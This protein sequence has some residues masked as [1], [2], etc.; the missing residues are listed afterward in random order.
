M[1]EC[2][3]GCST[4]TLKLINL[5]TRKSWIR[6]G[7]SLKMSGTFSTT[8]VTIIIIIIWGIKL[9]IW[10]T[11]IG[12]IAVSALPEL[13]WDHLDHLVRVWTLLN[14]LHLH[15]TCIKMW[16]SFCFFCRLT[17]TAPRVH[18]LEGNTCEITWETIPP[19]RGDP[20]SYVL[21]VLVG[22][23]SEY[24]QVRLTRTL[25]HTHFIMR[26]VIRSLFLS[27]KFNDLLLVLF[28]LIIKIVI[29]TGHV[30]R[31]DS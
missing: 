19:M 16:R 28:H 21:Q 15:A 20:V 13:F 11:A 14:G 31:R 30:W 8:A 25:G 29:K 3:L 7:K 27:L 5:V 10:K 24:K 18:Q 26:I 23:E 22:R 9:F 17:P 2:P 12:I 1:K 4:G 6:W